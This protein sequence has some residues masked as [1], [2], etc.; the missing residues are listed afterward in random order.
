VDTQGIMSEPPGG[1]NH[2]YSVSSFKDDD[3]TPRRARRDLSMR[4]ARVEQVGLGSEGGG[5]DVVAGK[6]EGGLVAHRGVLQ[7][8]EYV[9]FFAL[10]AEVEAELGFTYGDVAAAYALGRPSNEQR[11]LREKIDARLL[12]LSRAGGNMEQ[13]ARVLD[14][15]EKTVDRALRRARVTDVKP[16]VA[17]GVVKTA[18]VCF[19][20]EAPAKARR[21]RFSK[22][23]RPGTI[24]LCD[25]HYAA[26]FDKH[27]GNRA[28]WAFRE[29]RRI[30]RD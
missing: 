29:D 24:D 1:E 12:A 26:G 5:Y 16:M 22:A 9:D 14:L 3:E 25:E 15:S 23:E 20:C 10:R 13:L 2:G 6:E 30:I 7:P 27:P 28:Y 18:R 11:Q 4:L 19:K 8:D 21:R 17:H